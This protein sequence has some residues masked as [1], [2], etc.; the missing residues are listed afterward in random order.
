MKIFKVTLIGIICSLAFIQLKAQYIITGKSADF[1]ELQ[2]LSNLSDLSELANLSEL[3]EIS[4]INSIEQ[5]RKIEKR[6]FKDVSKI[7][8]SQRGGKV[9]IKESSS[10]DIELT[11]EYVSNN[12]TSPEC[13]IYVRNGELN[14]KTTKSST[15]G[16]GYYINYT[17]TIPKSIGADIVIEYGSL[18]VD[19]IQGNYTMNLSY[20]N[21]IIGEIED[22]YT[23]DIS[24][25]Y[26]SIRIDKAK[27]INL[28]LNYSKA[29]IG[30]ANNIS[31]S[32]MYNSYA[33]ETINSL[34]FKRSSQYNKYQI[35]SINSMST[36]MKYDKIDIGKLNSSLDIKSDYSKINIKSI[37]SKAKLIAINGS[38]SKINIA[39]DPNISANVNASVKYGD[40]QISN[41]LYSKVISSNK[42]DFKITKKLQLGKGK[43][44][45]EIETSNTYANININSYEND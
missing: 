17:V 43:P 5:E 16:Q 19:K 10:K 1:S 13:E 8:I 45:L 25:K 7:R 4:A 20:S 33:F 36:A 3:S 6:T 42:G 30:S 41:K 27:D 18:K 26:G 23:P 39:I 14:I 32:G 38:Y 24:L 9:I 2:N 44:S 15:S 31:L 35:G 37:S 40:I 34:L 21:S 28:S 22:K 11:A 29:T 12:K